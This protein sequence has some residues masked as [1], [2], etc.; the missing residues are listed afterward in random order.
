MLEYLQ[1]DLAYE[2][3]RRKQPKIKYTTRGLASKLTWWV[4]EWWQ[5]SVVRPACDRKSNKCLS[6][7]TV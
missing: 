6:S 5:T 4:D 7:K 1:F 3:R 2:S